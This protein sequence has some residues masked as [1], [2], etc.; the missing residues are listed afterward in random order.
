MYTAFSVCLFPLRTDLPFPTVKKLFR[1]LSF[2]PI[3]APA[4][5]IRPFTSLYLLLEVYRVLDGHKLQGRH[6]ELLRK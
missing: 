3:T 6:Q 4:L 1:D 5:P 2:S